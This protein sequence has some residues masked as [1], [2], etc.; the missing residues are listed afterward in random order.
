MERKVDL[1]ALKGEKRLKLDNPEAV[2]TEIR[3]LYRIQKGL[4]KGKYRDE[5]DK[6]IHALRCK[7]NSLRTQTK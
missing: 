4:P 2:I 7:E 6:Q 1:Y 5:L 3:D